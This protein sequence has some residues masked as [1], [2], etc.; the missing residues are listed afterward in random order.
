MPAT[1]YQGG[2]QKFLRMNSVKFFLPKARRQKLVPLPAELTMHAVHI[3][4]AEESYDMDK[5]ENNK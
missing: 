3:V 4:N 2:G 1:I 5:Y